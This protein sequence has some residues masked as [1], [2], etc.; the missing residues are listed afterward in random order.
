MTTIRLT[1]AQ[2]MVR[3][4]SVQLNE[5]GERFIPGIW[6]IFGH[7]NVAGLGEALYQAQHGDLAGNMPFPTWRGQN[8]QTMA[9]TAIA[10]A[11]ARARRQAHAVTSSIGPGATNLVTAAALAH[12]NRLPLL[13]IPGDVFANRRPD[14]VLQ[15]IEDFDDG[16]VS[17]NDCFRPVV[18]Y[19][20][21][22]TRPE[23]LLS[24]L[25]RALRVMTDP[26]NCGPVCLSFCQDVQAEAHDWPE[27][28]F[29][30]KVWHVRRPDPD[31]REVEEVA[32]LIRAAQRPA[33]IAGGGVIY[34]GAETVLGDFARRFGIPVTETQ[35]GKSALAQ[36]DEMNFGAAGVDGS[37]AA[38]AAL[39][40]ADLVIGIGT[41][42]QDFTTGSRALFA[43]EAKL[44]SINIHGYDA[45]KHGAISLVADAGAA[46]ARLTTALGDHP[47][48]QVD[49]AAR[50]AWLA[51]VESKCAIPV[52]PGDLP[53]DAQVIGAVQ[54]ATGPEAIALCAAGTMPGA[55]K[56]LWRPSQGGYHM[57][58]GYSCM[59]YE[60]AGAL[61]VKL[62][63]PE[64]EVICFVGDGSY[65]MA[66]SE[67][68]TAVMRRV[69]F[70]VVLTDNR[71]YGC[72]N[73]LQRATTGGTEFN[74][75]Y[76][77]CTV[78]AQPEIDYV[79]HAA[80]LGAHAVKAASIDQLK[81]E[82]A[83]ARDRAIPSVI[84]IETTATPGP[85]EGLPGAGAW[86]DVAV[87]E[88]GGPAALRDA[89]DRYIANAARVRLIN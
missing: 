13:L 2:A 3:W 47:A 15:Q 79:A 58:Y 86:W 59:G 20:D 66:N 12:V 9:H 54:A 39:A 6:A 60:I 63:R 16:T 45:A 53:V 82:I 81:A 21:R 84:V 23:Q 69:P 67:L 8:E 51:A 10:F 78:E 75:L 56:L 34:S 64:R 68:A 48:W 55:L 74:N 80:S 29:T 5:E 26:A 62:A 52:L 1:A 22:I 85:G 4:L 27:A 71:G 49:A 38:N 28:F 30:P 18:R 37:A 65:M 31:P 36:A 72:I 42:L 57:E 70:T 50:S 41:R 83:A 11:K 24:A 25:P 61:G 88:T 7:G 43:A 17:A 40:A 73:R 46:L 76:K 77:D 33:I 35:A 32:A 14:P 44:V 89:Y 87:P 19:F